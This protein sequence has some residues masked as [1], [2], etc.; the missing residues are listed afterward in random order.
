MPDRRSREVPLI[1]L[2]CAVAGLAAAAAAAGQSPFQI[3]IT[4]DDGIDSPG[5]QALALALSEV[6]EVTVVAPCGQRS[7]ASMS[8]SLRAPLRLQT[9]GRTSGITEHC[10]DTTPA[11]AASLAI[12]TLAPEGG[13]DL[14]V[15][16][17]NQ[18]SNAGIVSHG[19]GTV[20]G[21]MMGAWHGI[22]A[23]AASLGAGRDFAY[24]A[25]FVAGFVRELRARPQLPGIVFSINI[26]TARRA[27][28]RGVAV[29]PMGGSY[30]EIGY[31]EI[32][33]EAEGRLFRPRFDPPKP[34]PAGSDSEAFAANMITI[35]P[36]AFDWTAT[37]ILADVGAWG[38]SP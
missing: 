8:L 16:G 33:G 13:F 27:D 10:V 9:F 25:Q 26:P 6:G 12:T 28:I 37:E 7:G 17:I 15:S 36:L 31:D 2:A 19:S 23:V 21:A 4:N 11:G 34:F 29:V 20:G 3:L 32:E 18:G 35:T 14:V 1:A 22:P 24:P 30:L 5:I 38:L